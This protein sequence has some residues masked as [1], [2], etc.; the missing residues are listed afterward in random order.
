MLEIKI[1]LQKQPKLLNTPKI[2]TWTGEMAQAVELLSSTQ[3]T[4]TDY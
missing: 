4:R 3:R 1:V 2:V